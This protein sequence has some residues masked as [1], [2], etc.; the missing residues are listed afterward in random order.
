MHNELI[1][2]TKQFR[3]VSEIVL[4]INAK[5]FW[6]NINYVSLKRNSHLTK[7]FHKT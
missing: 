4:Q 5:M 6:N 7:I 1:G 2:R 3:Y